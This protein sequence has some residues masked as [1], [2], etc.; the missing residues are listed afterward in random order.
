MPLY[1]RCIPPHEGLPFTPGCATETV[2]GPKL[3]V[4]TG[5]FTKKQMD[6]AWRQW[7]AKHAPKEGPG[8]EDNA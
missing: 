3:P 1:E 5:E 6:T 2:W 8:H 7:I 4:D